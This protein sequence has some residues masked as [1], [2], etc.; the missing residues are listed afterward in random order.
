[1]LENDNKGVLGDVIERNI[2]SCVSPSKKIIS[3]MACD[4]WAPYPT[5]NESGS[6][7]GENWKGKKNV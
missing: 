7:K 5:H 4:I 6:S 3:C 2:S 1:M